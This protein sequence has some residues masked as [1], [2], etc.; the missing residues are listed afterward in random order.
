MPFLILTRSGFDDAVSNVGAPGAALHIN[1]GVASDDEVAALRAAGAV[2]H[3]LPSMVDPKKTDQVELA[4]QA[5]ARDGDPVWLERGTAA[6]PPAAPA[7]AHEP[8]DNTS[9]EEHEALHHRLARTAGAVARA[10]LRGLSP[11]GRQPMTVP[12]LGFGNAGKLW[13]KGR[14]LDE[15]IFREQAGDDS[16]WSNLMALYQRL[17]SDEVAGAR[18]RAHFQGQSHETVTDRGGYFSFEIVPTQPVPGGWQTVELELPDSRGEDG[19][20]VRTKA[21]AMVPAPTARFGIISDI[22]DTVLWTNVT[23]KLNM[24]LMLAR[25]N[26]HTRKPFKGVGAF[27]R[28]LRHGAGGNEDNP[29][30][31][32]SS[33][34]WHLF[35]PLVEFLRLQGIPVGPL[36]LRELG[37]RE[38]FKLTSHGNHKLEKIELILSY[39]PDMQF[40]LIGDSGEQDPE[41]YTE[42]V[43]RHPKQVKVIYIRDVNPDPARIEAL[44]KLIA[45][46]SA[47]GTQLILA[48]DSVF[49]ASHA[50][51][52][53]LI[54]VDRLASVR[55]DKKEDD[56]VLPGA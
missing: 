39:Y 26:A 18:V 41:I 13:V 37:V 10:A 12:Y 2:V 20:P 42:V 34:P 7:V 23:N 31:Y 3:I 45:E 25:S 16:R 47:T 8:G 11:G 36:L 49:A 6:T 44:D 33:S 52:E 5:A 54:H 32:V 24:A 14:V 22:D 38:V 27:Y 35:G 28:A 9:A 51:A 53:G 56:S 15:S 29:V 48:P 30:F 50:A 43:R 1:P 19:Q 4:L 17:E 55:S 21:E 46:V 40:V